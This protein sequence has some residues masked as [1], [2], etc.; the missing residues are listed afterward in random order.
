MDNSPLIFIQLNEVNFDFVEHYVR[1]YNDL[2]AFAHVLSTFHKIET[3]G[4]EA[5]E[6]LEPWIQWVSVQT[7]KTYAE[8]C[9][10]R[11]GDVVKAPDDLVQ[12]FEALEERGLRVG[13]ISPMNARNRLKHPAYFIPDPWTDTPA[14]G[15]GFSTRLSAMLRQTVNENASG[16][17]SARSV[18]TLLEAL[19]FSFSLRG[20]QDLIRTI[21]ATRR[22][23]WIK[24]LVLDRLLHLVHLRLLQ[25]RRP[26]VSFAFLNAGAHI[27]HHY[28]LNAEPA[29]A[30]SCNPSW[31]VPADAD[32]VRD[33]L[34]VYDSILGDYLELQKIG[35]KVL[36]A[37]GLT[38]VPYERVKFYYRLKDHLDFLKLI[39]TAPVRVLPRMTRDFEAE[40]ANEAQA[41]QAADQ[42]AALTLERDGRP[43]FGEI[44]QRGTQVFV[45]LTYPDEIRPNDTLVRSN[46][47][48][49]QD[50]GTMVTFVAIKNGM[51]STRG[52]A[53][54]S[55]NAQAP[56]QLDGP[57]H[58]A[59]LFD[60]TLS[61]AIP[62]L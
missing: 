25:L 23:P 32:P 57:C 51:H 29:G 52:F 22:Q 17:I 35:A 56:S 5:Y 30:R 37:T 43:V 40:F 48:R 36:I 19:V 58:V 1:K 54:L 62:R 9:V 50:F 28:M 13:A 26:D 24:A 34:K 16:R 46:G 45:T 10:F 18:I 61:V 15:S 39:G 49:I 3:H 6:E 4:E 44:D 14:D 60:L 59:R 41:A 12:V 11:L 20:T 55:P 38:Q 27:Q 2:P 31:Y 7:G 8:H 33:M 42:L 47:D 21:A 53:F